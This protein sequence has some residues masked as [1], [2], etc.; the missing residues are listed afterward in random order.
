MQGTRRFSKLSNIITNLALDFKM[1]VILEP[2]E[3]LPY[4]SL[5]PTLVN[6]DLF[7]KLIKTMDPLCRKTHPC[8]QHS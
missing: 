2:K 7:R 8:V 4:S 6:Q 3:A 1:Y 5:I